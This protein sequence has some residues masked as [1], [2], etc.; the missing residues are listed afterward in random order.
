M[1]DVL[2]TCTGIEALFTSDHKGNLV[3]LTTANDKMSKEVF[4]WHNNFSWTYNGNLAGKSQIK[5]AV[6]AAGGFVD[7]PFRFSI[8]WNENWEKN[9]VST[10]LDA[11]CEEP[12][13]DHIYFRSPFVLK[14][15]DI[16][17]PD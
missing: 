12:G 17:N 5:E 9:P 3:T 10:D 6:K 8:M 4:K 2:P 7:A 14:K 15:N 11:H 13:G 1:K 16:K